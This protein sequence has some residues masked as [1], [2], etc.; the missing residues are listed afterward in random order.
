MTLVLNFCEENCFFVTQ[1][2]RILSAS[3]NVRKWIHEQHS[4]SSSGTHLGLDWDF[5]TSSPQEFFTLLILIL[6]EG[7]SVQ[8]D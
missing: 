8:F 6:L 2:Q 4:Q 7:L 1:Y 3:K 5:V